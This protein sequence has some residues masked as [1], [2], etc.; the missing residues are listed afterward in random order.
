MEGLC[1]CVYPTDLFSN[2]ILLSPEFFPFSFLHHIR[3]IR[4]VKISWDMHSSRFE[5]VKL[6]LAHKV[7]MH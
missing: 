7:E 5:D 3:Q 6:R 4:F 1:R 2:A